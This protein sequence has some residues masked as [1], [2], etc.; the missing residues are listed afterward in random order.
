MMLKR[1][2][3]LGPPYI[4]A[5]RLCAQAVIR[6]GKCESSLRAERSCCTCIRCGLSER[7][8]WALRVDEQG[9][10]NDSCSGQG[11]TMQA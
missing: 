5:I 11:G 1:Q 6:C 9:G 2:R 4:L 7:R 8:L 10:G 3:L